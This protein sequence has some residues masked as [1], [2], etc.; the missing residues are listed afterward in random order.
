VAVL[1]RRAGSRAVDPEN[2]G[3]RESLGRVKRERWCRGQV[4]EA[5]SV[6]GT[7]GC[8]GWGRCV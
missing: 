6:R 4:D 5:M 8:E 3:V 1:G 7:R 2:A